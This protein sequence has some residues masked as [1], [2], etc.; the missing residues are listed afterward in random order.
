MSGVSGTSLAS[1]SKGADFSLIA[2]IC[3]LIADQALPGSE[4]V[5]VS[6]RCCFLAFLPLVEVIRLTTASFLLSQLLLPATSRSEAVSTRDSSFM[7][8]GLL[9]LSVDEQLP[10]PLSA[11]VPSWT[12]PVSCFCV[13]Q[14]S[15][16]SRG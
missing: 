6:S 13:P 15:P 8:D 12:M 5:Q 1:P 3:F 10:P 14:P 2:C 4:E 16:W 7:W 11:R 9:A